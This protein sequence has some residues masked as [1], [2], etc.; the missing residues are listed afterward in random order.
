MTNPGAD[1]FKTRWFSVSSA[2]RLF[3]VCPRSLI[4]AERAGRI[5]FQRARGNRRIISLP[6]LYSAPILTPGQAA[7]L[8]RVSYGRVLHAINRRRLPA[9]RFKG[10]YRHV[11]WNNVSCWAR[12]RGILRKGGA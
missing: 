9:L 5:K 2:A 6:A 8:L 1:R 12:S 11:S 10:G 4:R 3:R 7:R